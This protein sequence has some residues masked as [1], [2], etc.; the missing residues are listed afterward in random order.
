MD[1]IRCGGTM[2]K[3][4]ERGVL[5]DHCPACNAVWLD[6]GELEALELGV[7]RSPAELEAALDVERAREAARQVSTI[8]LCPRCQRALEPRAIYG[9][10]ID[11][12]RHCGG[13][14]FDHREL[15]EV[16]TR[17]RSARATP[18]GAAGAPRGSRR[19]P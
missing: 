12:C 19:G 2:E 4:A 1:C 7:A 16:L 14:F 5:L 10:E 13:I 8:G 6:G 15:P 11:Q 9:V 17:S 18:G 3:R